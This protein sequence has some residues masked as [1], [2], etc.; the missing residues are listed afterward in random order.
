MY[1]N[2][3]NT[4]YKTHIQSQMSRKRSSEELLSL[5]DDNKTNMT[6]GDYL[7]GCDIMKRMRS[8]ESLLEIEMFVPK[9]GKAR[10]CWERK[11]FTYEGKPSHIWTASHTLWPH[12]KF[13][14][15][16]WEVKDD[17]N[18]DNDDEDCEKFA[19]CLRAHFDIKYPILIDIRTVDGVSVIDDVNH[20][21]ILYNFHRGVNWL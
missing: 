10:N 15:T 3:T 8:L 6:D 12:T 2:V 5:L 1:P 21:S 20:S 11:C 19:E 16:P 18:F 17:P 9:S 4:N 13:L 14:V 7:K